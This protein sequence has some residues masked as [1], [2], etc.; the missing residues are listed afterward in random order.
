[1][2]DEVTP[3]LDRPRIGY[4]LWRAEGARKRGDLNAAMS[5]VETAL[6]MRPGHPG[7]LGCL[8]ACR[9]DALAAARRRVEEDSAS[10]DARIELAALLADAEE[11]DDA[12]ARLEEARVA[13]DALG[14]AEET[15]EP[16]FAR[17]AGRI[18]YGL[19]Q[20]DE[21]LELMRRGTEPGITM[22]EVHYCLG[23]CHLARG[24]RHLCA[25]QFERLVA[26]LWWAVPLRYREF[27]QWRSE[28]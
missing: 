24:E 19:G 21:A 10:A 23:L 6:E 12:K 27:R 20:I 7:A 1:M 11:F 13:L 25:A 17:L 22:A 16:E 9:E 2:P 14:R 5:F 18:A 3:P 4:M 26:K 8:R 28:A 15:Q